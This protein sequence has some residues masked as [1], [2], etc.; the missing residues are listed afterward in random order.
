MKRDRS[1]YEQCDDLFADYDQAVQQVNR[2]GTISS[3]VL[4]LRDGANDGYFALTRD[5]AGDC[6]VY[7]IWSWPAGSITEIDAAGT[8]PIGGAAASAVT[9]GVPVPRDGS[10][11]GWVPPG[12]G[13]V[14]ALL[15]IYAEYTP[16]TPEPGWA[17]MP[18]AG[19]A[20]AQWPPFADEALF[21]NW[22]WNSREG[23]LVRLD[24]TV[25]LSPGTVFWV[26]AKPVLGSD[27]C[28]VARDLGG[29][30]NCVLPRG[31]YAYYQVLRSGGP[32]PPLARLLAD[33]GK[34]DLA[35][36]FQRMLRGDAAPVT[37]GPR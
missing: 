37:P 11:F 28:V 34:I 22:T 31:R 7:L 24:E 18:L 35:A 19:A 17:V 30:G 32:V 2:S 12:S 36:R 16:A 8:S 14:T 23:T 1:L 10:L 13:T 25:A 20:E 21:G 5:G 4:M 6:A 33:P 3:M 27:C 29:P 9:R 26:D 15:V